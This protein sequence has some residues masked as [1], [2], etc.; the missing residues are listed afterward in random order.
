MPIDFVEAVH[1]PAPHRGPVALSQKLTTTTPFQSYLLVFLKTP[2]RKLLGFRTMEIRTRIKGDS[3]V[4]QAF[5]GSLTMRDIGWLWSALQSDTGF[6]LF[7]RS[8]ENYA[9][10]CILK[11]KFLSNCSTATFSLIRLLPFWQ[12]FYC[13]AV[14]SSSFLRYTLSRFYT[15]EVIMQSSNFRQFRLSNFALS[16]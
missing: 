7:I 11:K 4:L 12:F 2:F 13:I 8:V 14:T 3:N 9:W 16:F 5:V 6:C 1:F 15:C 10:F